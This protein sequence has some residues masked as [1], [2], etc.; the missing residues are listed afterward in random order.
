MLILDN[1]RV[2]IDSTGC[3]GEHTEYY[4]NGHWR[5][6]YYDNDGHSKNV[7]NV[8]YASGPVRFVC[9]QCAPPRSMLAV[10]LRFPVPEVLLY[11]IT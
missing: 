10:A 3:N 2:L 1:Q 7:S 5:T 9:L 6:A 4:H 8:F 11:F